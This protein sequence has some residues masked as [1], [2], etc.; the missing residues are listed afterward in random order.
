M[1]YHLI[2]IQSII[3][4]SRFTAIGIPPRSSLPSEVVLKST[5]SEMGRKK[6]ETGQATRRL[7]GAGTGLK[8]KSLKLAPS[9]DLKW[10]LSAWSK[11]S[12]SNKKGERLPFDK[13]LAQHFAEC[14]LAK[15]RSL[16]PEHQLLL[17]SSFGPESALAASVLM[18]CFM[19]RILA[20]SV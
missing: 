16:P 10:A 1:P 18:E 19:R 12:G 2:A 13:D 7:K 3:L 8:P 5:V 9:R 14:I 6:A 11:V 15:V 20:K 17:K 4:Q